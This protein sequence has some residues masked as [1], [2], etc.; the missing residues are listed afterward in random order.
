M[1]DV[2][3]VVEVSSAKLAAGLQLRECGVDCPFFVR[4]DDF[5]LPADSSEEHAEEVHVGILVNV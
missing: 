3:G 1:Q 5:G 4:D 2:V